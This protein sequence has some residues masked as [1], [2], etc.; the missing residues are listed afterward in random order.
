IESCAILVPALRQTAPRIGREIGALIGECDVLF[1]ATDTG[2]DVAVR[3]PK[4]QKPER[5]VPLAQRLRLTRLSLNGET[6]FQLAPPTLAMG[7]ARVDLP[8]GSFLQAT[9]AAEETLAR[10]VLDGVGKAKTVADLFCGI[11]PFALHVAE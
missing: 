1:T 10:L 5:V 9:A 8:T 7:R 6:I 2:I 4:R 11:G 3:T